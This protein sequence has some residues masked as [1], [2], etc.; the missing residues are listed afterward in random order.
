[1]LSSVRRQGHQP[2]PRVSCGMGWTAG[3]IEV[4]SSADALVCSFLQG[5]GCGN[6]AKS[7]AAFVQIPWFCGT[8]S[9]EL[10]LDPQPQVRAS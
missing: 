10:D 8:Q 9:K 6:S 7:K 2:G 1:M 4:L 3:S 5:S